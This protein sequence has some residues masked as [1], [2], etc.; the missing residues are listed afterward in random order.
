MRETTASFESVLHESDAHTQ[1]RTFIEQMF[2]M[3]ERDPHFWRLYWSL[4]VQP[5]IPERLQAEFL[6][7]IQE[8]LGLFA[9]AFTRLGSPLPLADAW[10]FAASMD[11]LAMYY[12]FD[13]ERCP[14]DVIRT[15][16]YR[17]YGLSADSEPSS[18]E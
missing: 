10:L 12:L 1:V 8:M 7:F 15:Q 11:G 18:P 5:S 3:V 2:A 17:R 13:P 4:L 9:D 6:E 14:I 16:I